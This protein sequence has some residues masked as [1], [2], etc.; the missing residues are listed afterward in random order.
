MVIYYGVKDRYLNITRIVTHVLGC[1]DGIAII[2]YGDHTR[3]RIFG[4]PAYGVVKHIKV[5]DGSTETHYEAHQ[6]LRFTLDTSKTIINLAVFEPE[7]ILSELHQR[8]KLDC[9]KDLYFGKAS[10]KDEY[11]EQIMSSMYIDA[12]DT[13]LELGSNIGRNTLV[14]AN[15]LSDDQRLVTLETDPHSFGLLEKNRLVNGLNF[16]SVNAA[17]SYRP[18]MQKDWITKPVPS[19]NCIEPGHYPVLTTT[20]DALQEKYQLKFNCLVLDCEGAIHGI[21]TEHPEIMQHITKVIIENDYTDKPARNKVTVDAIFKSYGLKCVYTTA[22]LPPH[23][24]PYQEEFYEVW[25]K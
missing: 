12:S 24:H 22:L 23:K 6:A 7:Q 11:P 13:V 20:F 1:E 14:I 25:K 19:D 10:M 16:H 4:D 18:L 8:I 5:V 15:L 2:P 17:L 21:L 3:C 9:K